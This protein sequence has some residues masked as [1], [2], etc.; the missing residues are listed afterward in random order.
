MEGSNETPHLM[1]AIFL[2]FKIEKK[3]VTEQLKK[4]SVI[5]K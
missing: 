5:P 2:A 1:L 4:K 3:A